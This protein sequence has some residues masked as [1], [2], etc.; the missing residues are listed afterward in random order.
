VTL[1]ERLRALAAGLTPRAVL[2][3]LAGVQM[4]DLEL[5]TTDGRWLVLRRH[6]QPAPAVALVLGQLKLK[7]PEQSPPRLSAE[8]KLTI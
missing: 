8:R 7:L 3:T 5:P 4:L 2:E 6:T 1:R